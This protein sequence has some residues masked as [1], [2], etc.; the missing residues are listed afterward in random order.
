MT[1]QART[2]VSKVSGPLK[3]GRGWP[4]GSQTYDVGKYGC[5]MEEFLLEGVAC[6]Y[7]PVEGSEVGRSGRWETEL[8]GVAPYRT[9]VYVV[10]PEDPERFNGVLLVNWQNV[11]AGVD[12]GLPSPGDL[13]RGFA[14][15]GVTAQRVAIEGQAGIRGVRASTQGL[16]DWDPE[17]YGSL[18]HPGDEYSYDLFS[19]AGRALGRD[20]P[21]S[22]IDPLGG[23][24]PRMLLAMG[25]SQSAMRL[26]SYLNVAHERDRVFDGFFPTVHW[27]ICPYPPDQAL[28]PSFA[29]I[30]GG[31]FAGSSQIRDGGGAPVLVLCSESETMHNYPVRQPDSEGF[32]FWEMAGTAHAGEVTSEAEAALVRDGQAVMMSNEER[33]TVSWSYVRDAALQRLVEWVE[34][35]QAPASFPPIEVEDGIGGAIRRDRFGNAL[36]GVRL[37]DLVAPTATHSGTNLGNPLAALAGLST[38]LPADVVR[39]LYEDAAAYLGVWDSAVD[40][41]AAAGLVLPDAVES[42]RKTGRM[43]A[44]QRWGGEG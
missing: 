44:A 1:K 24:Q 7:R 12:L 43:I 25:P 31:H 14:W 8:A 16:V 40:E 6:S 38:P 34:T 3:G 15:A 37:P 21:T 27:G 10:R 36:G 19:Q 30:G 28:Q 18:V 13:E 26:G 5:V 22:F 11:T 29:P 32:R 33:N 4:F 17:R 42:V 2:S 20:R 9:R 39:E 23:L 35:G 41:L